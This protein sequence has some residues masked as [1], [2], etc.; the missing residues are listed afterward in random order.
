MFSTTP[1]AV[2]APEQ[3]IVS[4][5]TPG[6]GS[7]P[8]RVLQP[9]EPIDLTSATTA[10]LVFQS[11]L[12]S[13]HTTGRVQVSLDGSTWETVATVPATEGWASID[14]DLSAYVGQIL[15][16]RFVFEPGPA[17]PG[18]SPDSWQIDDVT[19]HIEALLNAQLKRAIL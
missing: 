19:V 17:A 7:S 10:H 16:I 6:S 11:W 2:S 5:V 4:G 13:R 1:G 3:S 12:S 18:V 9:L 14:A 15:Y 8:A